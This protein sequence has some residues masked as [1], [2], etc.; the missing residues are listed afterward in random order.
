MPMSGGSEFFDR[1]Q[2]E[3]TGLMDELTP[4]VQ[5]L[6]GL[7]KGFLEA[8]GFKEF[9]AERARLRKRILPRFGR[10]AVLRNEYSRA[11]QTAVFF[12]I[13]GA[14][15]GL[16]GGRAKPSVAASAI[17]ASHERNNFADQAHRFE[18]QVNQI[19]KA[20]DEA[21][22]TLEEA[23]AA[24]SLWRRA[25]AAG[26][27]LALALGAFAFFLLRSS[28][29]SVLPPAAGAAAAIRL[30]PGDLIQGN[31]RID[32]DI[33][34]G[35]SGQICEA[36]DL[37]LGRKVVIQRLAGESCRNQAALDSFMAAAGKAAT[38]R[39]SGIAE[40]YAF[41]EEGGRFFQVR[42]FARGRPLEELIRA[43]RRLTPS[44]AVGIA[45]QAASALD[46]AHRAGLVHGD[47]KPSNILLAEDGAVKILDFGVSRLL[48]KEPSP[49]RAPEAAAGRPVPASDV[50]SLAEI[51]RFFIGE[52]PA[53]MDEVLRKAGSERPE[54]RFGSAG[55]FAEALSSAVHAA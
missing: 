38:L 29:K 7:R 20:D 42:E 8:R 17:A 52:A 6:D 10:F 14:V 9:S 4:M 31:Y 47:L 41:F 18:Y 43:G 1:A 12:S 28:P 5:G 15:G 50:Y 39:H 51:L 45:R 40:I 32:R 46:C 30:E 35:P 16:G 49:C 25:A 48:K 37:A 22:K 2:A 54:D 24:R 21:F 44:A 55:E 3:L 33:G 13:M 23:E 34:A 19:L 27:A 11:R 26:L 36:V 53:R